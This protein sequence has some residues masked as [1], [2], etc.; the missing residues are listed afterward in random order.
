VLFG[1]TSPS[2]AQIR[3]AQSELDRTVFSAWRIGMR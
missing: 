2:A 3:Q 1:R